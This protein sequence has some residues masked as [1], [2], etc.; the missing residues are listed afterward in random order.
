MERIAE[1]EAQNFSVKFAGNYVLK[2]FKNGK[3]VEKHMVLNIV[4]H[5][6]Y[7]GIRFAEQLYSRRFFKVTAPWDE[8]KLIEEANRAAKTYLVAKSYTRLNTYEQALI[9]ASLSHGF[10]NGFR[11][12]EPKT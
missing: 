9:R 2:K 1:A 7:M 11:F 8:E 5:G 12:R 10:K 4:A 3:D 6:H